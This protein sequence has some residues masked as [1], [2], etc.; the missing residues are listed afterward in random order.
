MQHLCW[1]II[2]L[3]LKLIL[4]HGMSDCLTLPMLS[5]LANAVMSVQ[6]W[7]SNFLV[8]VNIIF[9]KH[10]DIVQESFIPNRNH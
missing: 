9:H 1:I 6:L 4:A 7:K 8:E 2:A 3:K 10:V 5:I